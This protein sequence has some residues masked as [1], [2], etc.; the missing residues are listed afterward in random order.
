MLNGCFNNVIMA[1]F[2]FPPLQRGVRGDLGALKNPPKS[3]FFKG[4]LESVFAWSP[5]NGR[6]APRDY[7]RDRQD[8]LRE[9]SD[10]LSS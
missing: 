1:Y 4:G 2:R 3:P 9:E 7:A 5:A 10:G 8:K 6:Q